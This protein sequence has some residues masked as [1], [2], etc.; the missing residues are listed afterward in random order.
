[1][2]KSLLT[3]GIFVA[4]LAT[5]GLTQSFA[6]V[7]WSEDFSDQASSTTNWTAGGTNDG[8][9][10]W[11]WTND[12]DAGAWDGP[13]AGPTASTGYFYFDSDANGEFPH[14]VTLSGPGAG[15]D[16]SGKTDVRLK[17]STFFRTFNGNDVAQVGVSTDGVNYTYHNIPE[18]DALIDEGTAGS[19]QVV[20][21]TVEVDIDEADNQPAVWIQFRWQGNFE[22]YWKVD[23]I[24]LA[25]YQIPTYDI[26][27][28]VNASLITLDPAGMK[29]AGTFNGFA[30][31]DMTDE[32]NGVW[33]YTHTFNEG[34]V[35]LYKFKNGPS[36]WES[37]QQA[38]GVDDG[39]GGYNRT[40]TATADAVLAAICFNSC[41]PCQVTCETNPDKIICDNFDAYST[42]QRLGPQA[43]WWST[44]SGT[45]GTTEDGIVSTEQGFSA[46]NS[47]KIISTAAGGGPQDVVLNLGNKTSGNYQLKWKMFVPTGKRGYYNI[48]N[49]VPI[50]AGDWNLD[51]FFADANSGNIQIGAGAS[52]ASFTYPQN[53]WFD[54]EHLI[55]LD[56]NLLTLYIDGVFVKKMA[57]AKNLGGIDF[58]GIDNLHEYF[59]DNVEYVQLPAVVFN[60][61]V[62]DAAVDISGSLGQ[63]AGIVTTVGPYDITSAT[64]DP[65]NDP[66]EGFECHS[67]DPLQGNHW[68]TFVGDGNTYNIKSVDC[69]ASPIQDGD[70]QF[71]L[72][73]GSCGDYTPLDCNDDVAFPS[74]L[75]STLTISTEPGVVYYLMV[76]SWEGYEG[77]YCLEIS[78]IASIDCNNALVGLNLLSSEYL[79]WGDVLTSIMVFDESTY[80]I[81]NLG[82]IGGHIWVVSEQPLDP[83]VFP[84]GAGGGLV[85][86]FVNPGIPGL[87]LPNDNSFLTAPGEY[88]L[89]SVLLAGGTLIDPANGASIFNIDITNGCFFMGESHKFVV[90]PELQEI[91]AF[92]SSELLPSGNVNVDLTVDGGFGAAVGDPTLYNFNWSNGATTATLSDVPNVDYSV[93]ISDITGCVD[94]F[95]VDIPS[96]TND[97]STVKVLTLT[98]NPTSGFVNLNLNLVT[99]AD[100]QIEVVNTLGQ[101]IQT[102]QA[103][104]TATLTQAIDLTTAPSGTYILRVR[105]DNESAVRRVTVQH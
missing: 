92:G 13:W 14:D 55:D 74:D 61:D 91:V 44:W 35:V 18:F 83:N 73:T 94:D 47:L 41:L 67:N 27:F 58:F 79:C 66:T 30:D 3:K 53:E 39:F 96:S 32:G 11:V 1:M 51:V 71:S 100:V 36:G 38:C 2:L 77:T 86:G 5:L 54:V 81:P 6:Q 82:P 104:K 90:V 37:G 88:Y 93:T 22:Y 75:H 103:G 70:T 45:E 17:F 4:L 68:F 78:Q 76:D 49:V 42:A 95:V 50:G 72:Y 56:N 57:F 7:F 65:V 105:M 33:S 101:N 12:A 16:C 43:T 80:T 9:L 31:A 21:G 60:A 85:S 25:E 19:A 99:A 29:I 15:I 98:P 52:L 28:R 89:T 23:D 10:D 84:D 87:N 24:T 48:Q 102:I 69:G 46:P 63:A 62:C 8:P 20:D 64:L 26:T 59:V 34:D 97:P 40:I